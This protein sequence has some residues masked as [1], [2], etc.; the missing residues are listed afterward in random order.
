MATMMLTQRRGGL[1][2]LRTPGLAGV[3]ALQVSLRI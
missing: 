2:K 3:V 1:E